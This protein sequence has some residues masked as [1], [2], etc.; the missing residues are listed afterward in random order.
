M[1]THHRFILVLGCALAGS[2]GAQSTPPPVNPRADWRVVERL[3]LGTAISVKGKGW[4][5]FRCKVTGSDRDS[6]SCQAETLPGPNLF[7]PAIYHFSRSEIR[8]I[9]LEHPDATALVA[10]VAVGTLGAVEGAHA[11]DTPDP[12]GSILLGG[13]GALIA[14]GIGHSFPV[15]GSVIYQP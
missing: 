15:H 14:A 10:G 3:P 11:Q 2:A 1:R 9:R 13:L 7:P 12:A 5:R 6:L 8:Q 4:H